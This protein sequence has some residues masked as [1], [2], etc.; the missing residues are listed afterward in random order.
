MED[1]FPRI[2]RALERPDVMFLPQETV[3]ARL[4]AHDPTER[5]ANHEH[6][7]SQILQAQSSESNGGS[8]LQS[9]SQ[10][11]LSSQPATASTADLSQLNENRFARTQGFQRQQDFG[12]W[13]NS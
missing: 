4:R 2:D 9:R 12:A 6:Q 1:D 8:R 7:R 3:K 10:G 13:R 5:A 11:D